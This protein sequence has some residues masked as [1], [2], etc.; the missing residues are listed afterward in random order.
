MHRGRSQYVSPIKVL[1]SYFFLHRSSTSEQFIRSSQSVNIVPHKR[2]IRAGWHTHTH[3]DWL[4]VL[5]LQY[6]H[7]LPAGLQGQGCRQQLYGMC[8]SKGQV[9]ILCYLHLLA[10][11]MNTAVY[12]SYKIGVSGIESKLFIPKKV[13][14]GGNAPYNPILS[15]SAQG[16]FIGD[17][18]YYQQIVLHALTLCFF[19]AAFW[20]INGM[21]R[22]W[23]SA[24]APLK[25]EP[26][27]ILTS[28]GISFSV[29]WK[30]NISA[31]SKVRIIFWSFLLTILNMTTAY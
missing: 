10:I 28:H 29:I 16:A 6:I 25:W 4:Q 3:L 23:S 30:V 15:V 1:K 19:L 8:Q 17:L 31:M 5:Q 2:S 7:S 22:V 20:M 13:P 26:Q 12:F 11:D 24:S 9:I 14:K 18:R 27:F 21:K